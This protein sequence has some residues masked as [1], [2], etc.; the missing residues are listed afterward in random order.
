MATYGNFPGVRITTTGGGLTGVQVGGEEVLTLFGPGA[1]DPDSEDDLVG[2]SEPTQF[3]SIS[4]AGR[5]F[6]DGSP[7]AES[8][9]QAMANGA[10]RNYLYG[11]RTPD[12]DV[13]LE[14]IGAGVVDATAHTDG[15]KI[16]NTPVFE[17]EEYITVSE[18]GTVVFDGSAD[19]VSFVF[20]TNTDDTSTDFSDG[21]APDGEFE[22]N[23]L[24][25]EWR[26][27]GTGGDYDISY[28]Y[29]DYESAFEGAKDV[30]REGD[31]GVYATI[32]E[33]PDVHGALEAEVNALRNNYQMV[34]GVAGARPNKTSDD[35]EAVFETG[36]YGDTT[37]S[38]VM[39]LAGP[40]RQ[41]GYSG[42]P[43]TIIGALGGLMAGNPITNPIYNDTLSGLGGLVERFNHTDAENMR[44]AE[45]IPIRQAGSIRVK[46]NRS[47]STETDWTRDFWRRRIVDRVLLVSKQVGDD[48][49][50][51]INDGDTRED[52]ENVIYAQLTEMVDDR[53]LKENTADETRWYVEVVGRTGDSD[54]VSIDLGITPQGVV[55][56]IDQSVTIST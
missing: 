20:E 23:P 41:S 55:K 54:G 32:T 25:G 16:Q 2:Y 46:D 21:V 15:A 29:H 10:N 34:V 19:E 51:R 52:A 44:E 56:R 5:K 13:D 48:T 53:L 4:D 42:Q 26:D 28:T 36:T 31:S 3:E 9:Q 22:L 43:T 30:L 8:V 50:G 40:A 24:T 37:D 33:A 1:G 7:L 17:E 47:T 27:D 38:D 45:V 6:G 35:G 12:V 11:V 14:N 39:F 18:G 49:I